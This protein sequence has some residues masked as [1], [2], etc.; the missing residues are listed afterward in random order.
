MV[1]GS[2]DGNMIVWDKDRRKK[3]CKLPEAIGNAKNFG[4]DIVDADF[5]RFNQG[6]M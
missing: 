1:T 6:M 2:P 4:C 3:V 5:C